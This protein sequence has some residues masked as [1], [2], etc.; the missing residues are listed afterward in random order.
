MSRITTVIALL[1]TLLL[2][3]LGAPAQAARPGTP[4]EDLALDLDATGLVSSLLD[5]DTSRIE[6]DVSFLELAGEE[7]TADGDT[8][9]ADATLDGELLLRADGGELLGTVELSGLAVDAVVEEL[10][11]RCSGSLQ[12]ELA[13]QVDLEGGTARPRD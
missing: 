9:I 10:R 11:A 6:L 3:T 2:A 1:T 8:V 13:L 12:A 4:F 7:F 5:V